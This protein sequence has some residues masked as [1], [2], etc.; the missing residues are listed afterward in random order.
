MARPNAQ[1]KKGL[2][3]FFHNLQSN[4]PKSSIDK[5]TIE[6]AW[7]LMDKVVTLCAGRRMNLKNSPPFILDILPETYQQ[8]RK[9]FKNYEAQ[10]EFLNENEYFKLFI[11]NL[12]D[13]CKQTIQLFKE[14]KD[15]I[16]DEASSYRRSLTK[17]SL[18]FSHM[19][20]EL[21]AV[22]PDGIYSGSAYRVTKADAAEFWFTSF[23]SK[24]V[25]PVESSWMCFFAF[26]SHYF[27]DFI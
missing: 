7:K 17:Q 15:K 22:F 23:G 2:L 11:E 16:Y 4:Q 9:I 25:L 27:Y 14:A 1:G 21:K 24:L 20:A 26:C 8:L 18:I 5:K 3:G 10:L 13:K 6:K 12:M 19:L